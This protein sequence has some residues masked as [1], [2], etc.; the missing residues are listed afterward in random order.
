MAVIAKVSCY[1]QYLGLILV[2][3]LM[4]EP[5]HLQYILG[6]LKLASELDAS[7]SYHC[8]G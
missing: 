3:C 7:G 6:C 1:C 5:L 4:L 2:A 8:E